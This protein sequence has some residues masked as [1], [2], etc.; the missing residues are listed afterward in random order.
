MKGIQLRVRKRSEQQDGRSDIKI[1]PIY[2]YI[3]KDCNHKFEEMRSFSQADAPIRCKNCGSEATHRTVS[4]C[5]SIGD[6]ISVSTT[7]SGGCA[8][9]SGGNCAHCH[10]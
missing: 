9:C 10:S 1:M 5:Y 3:C 4:K 6:G 7:V 8:G 2:E